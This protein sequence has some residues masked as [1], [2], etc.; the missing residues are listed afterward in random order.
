VA[1]CID[2][3][4]IIRAVEAPEELVY[5]SPP[6]QTVF[7]PDP[8]AI[9]KNPPHRQLAQRFVQ[10]VLSRRGQ[11]I[12]ALRVGAPDGP[13]RNPLGRLPIRRDVYEAYAQDLLPSTVNP[14]H[15]GQ[16]M[17]MTGHRTAVSFSTLRLLVG[18][19]AVDNLEGL[20]R[21][22]RKLIATN[23]PADRLEEFR[24]LPENVSTLER[25]A[26]T[27]QDLKDPTRREMIVT[28]WQRYFREKYERVA[29]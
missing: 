21:A 11:A 12:W 25:M 28:G 29:R 20:R 3:Y 15:L 24:R 19:A 9:L 10:F 7:T 8:I 18:A 14:Y 1:T 5:L 23:F 26:R 16:A 6:G 22:R 2:F 27:G 13:V 17:E 4:G